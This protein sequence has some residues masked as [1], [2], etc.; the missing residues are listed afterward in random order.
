M[1]LFDFVDMKV[2]FNAQ[3]IVRK[4]AD[5]RVDSKNLH[6]IVGYA[7]TELAREA[8]IAATRQRVPVTPKD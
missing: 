4:R 8:E 6:P 1:D 2:A 3:E 7:K 5:A